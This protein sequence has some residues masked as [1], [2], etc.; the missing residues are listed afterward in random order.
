MF[1]KPEEQSRISI[2]FEPCESHD[3]QLECIDSVPVPGESGSRWRWAIM[4]RRILSSNHFTE[5]V[6]HSKSFRG[7]TAIGMAPRRL[8]GREQKTDN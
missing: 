4:E 1:S 6:N 3:H 5:I 2:S 7:A 8:R